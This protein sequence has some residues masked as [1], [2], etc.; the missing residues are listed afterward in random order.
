[1]SNTLFLGFRRF[2]FCLVTAAGFAYP[3][4]GFAAAVQ[5]DPAHGKEL[6]EECSGCHALQENLIG[7]KH[8]GLMGRRAGTVPDYV[9]SDVMR[10]SGI[11]WDTKKLD[12][13]LKAPLSYLPGT[14]M[15]YA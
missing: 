4:P 9:Y 6:Y 14:N 3:L 15:G 2:A 10:Q 7:P 13:F 1:M 8:C 11:V 5:G 12:E